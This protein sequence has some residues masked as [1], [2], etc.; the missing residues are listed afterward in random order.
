MEKASVFFIAVKDGVS[1]EEVNIKLK[2]LLHRLNPFRN[3]SENHFVALKL[4]F[5]EQENTGYVHP[6]YVSTIIKEIKENK[7]RVF[8]TDTNALYK[9]SR[10]N[11]VEH[12]NLAYKHGFSPDAVGVP[13]IIADGLNGDDEQEVEIDGKFVKKAYIASAISKAD[14]LVVV[15][16]FKGHL[17]TGFGG[18]IKNLGMGCASRRGKLVQ[19]GG[20]APYIKK[21]TCIACSV[22]INMCPASAIKLV[23]NKAKIDSKICI[24]CASCIAACPAAA[25]DVQWEQG[26]DTISE[27]MSEY[28]KAAAL[29]KVCVY[30]NFALKITKECD[31]LAKDDPKICPDIGI[32]CSQ[33]AVS[34]DQ[35]CVDKVNE[36]SGRDLFKE[37]HPQRNWV[38]QLEYAESIGLGTRIYELKQ[39]E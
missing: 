31:C 25:I 21:D 19:H 30:I 34:V 4:H 10:T 38:R 33:D 39:I 3:I 28:A 13:V 36:V 23:N 6:L 14:S 1:I 18:A 16:H 20:I 27:R 37:Q 24:G 35:A 2:T 32:F 5:G 11:A 15:S 8:L 29:S 17:M 22:C 9:G 7:A 26:A 12:L